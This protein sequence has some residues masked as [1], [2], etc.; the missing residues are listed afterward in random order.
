MSSVDSPEWATA[1]CYHHL[2]ASPVEARAAGYGVVNGEVY[3]N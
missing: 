3:C 2:D 1:C